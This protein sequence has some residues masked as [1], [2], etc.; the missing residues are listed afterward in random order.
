MVG[1]KRLLLLTNSDFGQANVVLATAHELGLACQGVEI[2]I[3][4][5]QDLRGGVNDASRFMQ[6]IAAQQKKKIPTPF[7]FH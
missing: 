7:V 3:A 1:N 4:S 2:H 6:A 5:F